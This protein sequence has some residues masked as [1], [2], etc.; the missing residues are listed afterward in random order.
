MVESVHV[1][2]VE[3][4]GPVERGNR[5]LRAFLGEPGDAQPHKGLGAARIDAGLGQEV[6]LGLLVKIPLV[7]NRSEEEVRAAH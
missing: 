5:R 1:G 2:G 7:R 3:I 6:V 4:M